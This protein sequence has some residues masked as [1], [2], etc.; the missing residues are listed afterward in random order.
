MNWIFY[1]E[2][3]FSKDNP[4]VENT[5]ASIYTDVEFVH[6]STMKYKYEVVM[7]LDKLNWGNFFT[8]VIF[9]EISSVKTSFPRVDKVSNLIFWYQLMV[10][11]LVKFCFPGKIVDGEHYHVKM[12][13]SVAIRLL[14]HCFTMITYLRPDYRSATLWDSSLV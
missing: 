6:T 5:C 12:A 13:H 10:W 3:F 9:M 1:T 7:Y 4:I 14:V 2:I 8:N 11:I